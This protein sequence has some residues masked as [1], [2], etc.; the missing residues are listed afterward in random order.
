[1]ETAMHLKILL[2]FK[3]FADV[4]HV[5]RMVI[6]T[7]A[8]SYGLLPQRL[9]CTAALVPGIL[10]YETSEGLQYVAVD[11]GI[12]VKT[13]SEV[14]VSVRNAMGNAPLGQLK[15]LVQT[16]LKQVNENEISTRS[17]MAK[18]ESS[19]IRSIQKL[20]RAGE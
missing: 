2:P 15:A 10:Q 16:Q 14:L 17:M 7:N 9:D 8:G 3:V 13:G 11:E 18:L 6:E 1:M 20:R 4:E 19:F 5:Q 12:L